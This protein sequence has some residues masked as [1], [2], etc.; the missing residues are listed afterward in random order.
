MH[1]RGARGHATRDAPLRLRDPPGL[2]RTAGVPPMRAQ[3]TRHHRTDRRGAAMTEHTTTEGLSEAEQEALWESMRRIR[4]EDGS[5]VS[6]L[7]EH[8]EIHALWTVVPT[9]ERI[10]ADRLAA[11]QAERDAEETRAERLRAW[12]VREQLARI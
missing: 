11:V 3:R 12:S 8:D 4:V 6:I 1:L 10:L 5:P 9:V 2:V 7:K